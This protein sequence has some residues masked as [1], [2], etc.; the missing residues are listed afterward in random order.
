MSL[1]NQNEHLK[2]SDMAS[3]DR[4]HPENAKLRAKIDHIQQVNLQLQSLIEQV[5]VET[6]TWARQGKTADLP[7]QKF[8]NHLSPVFNQQ[9]AAMDEIRKSIK[10]VTVVESLITD[11]E[12]AA[13]MG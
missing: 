9:L 6:V 8:G 13:L 3:T 7:C 2:R 11:E 1:H 4:R 12:R 10:G 5:Q